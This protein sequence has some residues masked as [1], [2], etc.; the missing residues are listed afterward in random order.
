MRGG[1]PSVEELRFAEDEGAG[2]HRA[3]L[4]SHCAAALEPAFQPGGN[5]GLAQGKSW[6]DN[7]IIPIEW[8]QGVKTGED[9]TLGGPEALRRPAELDCVAGPA[10][11]GLRGGLQQ[12]GEIQDFTIREQGEDNTFPN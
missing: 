4:C 8:R 3:N 11:V 12:S 2:A 5:G 7:Q 1:L 6:H 10:G 9:K